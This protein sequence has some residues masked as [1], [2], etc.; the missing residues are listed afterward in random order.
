[1]TTTTMSLFSFSISKSPW[2]M[3]M[4]LL[5]CVSLLLLNTATVTADIGEDGKCP[6]F[7]FVPFTNK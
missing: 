6:I 3:L 4:W 5:L 2:Y 1:M 7:V